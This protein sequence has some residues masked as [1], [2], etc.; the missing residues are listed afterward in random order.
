MQLL[1]AEARLLGVHQHDVVAVAEAGARGAQRHDTGDVS[2]TAGTWSAARIAGQCSG[3]TPPP[4][5]HGEHLRPA[6]RTLRLTP[7]SPSLAMPT[8]HPKHSG[9]AVQGFT[10]MQ[11]RAIVSNTSSVLSLVSGHPG[12]ET[13]SGSAIHTH[14]RISSSLGTYPSP[15]SR[16]GVEGGRTRGCKWRVSSW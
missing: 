1:A 15:G 11:L 6:A 9:A 14:F 7:H 16:A 8:S 12:L 10:T 4:G 13:A 2:R 5:P 3:V